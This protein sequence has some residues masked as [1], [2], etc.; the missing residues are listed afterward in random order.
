MRPQG[1]NGTDALAVCR[2]G[3]LLRRIRISSER[4]RL[5]KRA[6]S[7]RGAHAVCSDRKD[8]IV[9]VMLA[10]V[11][12]PH[13]VLTLAPSLAPEEA[14][15]LSPERGLRLEKAFARGCGHGLLVLG[16]DEVGTTLPPTLSYW[17]K[18][19]ARYVTVLCALPGIG[20]RTKPPVPIPADGELDTMAAAVPP[21][22]GAEYL[23]TEV[24]AEA[25]ARNRFCFRCRV[26]AIQPHRAG[27]PQEPS[28]GLEPG[29]ACSFQSR[30]EP[31]G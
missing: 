9:M 19:A 10:P 21:M 2:Q 17:R 24:L 31:Q 16:A 27:V 20:E 3:G 26:G 25:V 4:A 29:G 11:L 7:P 1:P 6:R 23:T 14:P 22:T 15:A 5:A 30:G 28:P 12:S 13:G 8:A 18:F